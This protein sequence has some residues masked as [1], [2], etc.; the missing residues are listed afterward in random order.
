MSDNEVLDF[1]DLTRKEIKVLIQDETFYLQ[2]ATGAVAKRFDNLRLS[3]ITFVDG[4]PTA[5]SGVAD[6]EPMLVSMCLFR[7]KDGKRI[8]VDQKEIESWPARIQQTLFVKAKEISGLDKPE[9]PYV[10]LIN[11]A[12]EHPEAPA[13]PTQI[14]EWIDAL[15]DEKYDVIKKLFKDDAAKK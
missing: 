2:E 3:K 10:S 14:I 15:K 11:E 13:T 7:E 1:S 9:V 5:F 4:K 8:P 6:L 12:F